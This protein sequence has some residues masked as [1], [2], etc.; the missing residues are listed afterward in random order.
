MQL[1]RYSA[2]SANADHTIYSNAEIKH[3]YF[4]DGVPSAKL[5]VDKNTTVRDSA[6]TVETL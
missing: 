5:Y 2:G 6:E 3:K 4:P 1:C